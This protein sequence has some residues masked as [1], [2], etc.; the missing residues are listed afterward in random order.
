MLQG[1]L[2][3]EAIEVLFQFAGHFRGSTRPRAIHEALRTLIR[4]AMDPFAQGRIRK[5][6]RVRDVLHALAFDDLA[7]GLGTAEDARLFRLF[8]E[9]ISSGQGVIG[10]VQFEG[11]HRR[12]S[13]NK[14]LQQYTNPTS[15]AVF[16]LLSEQNLFASNFPGAAIGMSKSHTDQRRGPCHRVNSDSR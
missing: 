4:K 8:Q 11:P 13:S 10:K 2:I 3:D 1:V 6:E 7:Y 15:H 9:G 14:I 16:T 12:V 5:L